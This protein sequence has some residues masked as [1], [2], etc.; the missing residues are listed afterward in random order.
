MTSVLPEWPK[1]C[2]GSLDDPI[3][4]V[5]LPDPKKSPMILGALNATS[6]EPIPTGAEANER[7]ALAKSWAA[8]GVSPGRGTAWGVS[9]GMGG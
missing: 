4:V 6:G 5:L 2:M 7:S 8:D 3:T 9:P 1:L